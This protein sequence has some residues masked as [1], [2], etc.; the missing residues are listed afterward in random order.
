M[1]GLGWRRKGASGYVTAAH[2][3]LVDPGHV[4]TSNPLRVRIRDIDN[5]SAVQLRVH[6]DNCDERVVES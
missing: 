2:D 3:H 6:N 5:W 4:N 1:I